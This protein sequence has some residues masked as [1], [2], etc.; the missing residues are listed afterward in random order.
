MGDRRIIEHVD[1]IFDERLRRARSMQLLTQVEL[2]QNIQDIVL[3]NPNHVKEFLFNCGLS[4]LRQNQLLQQL[5][6][7]SSFPEDIINSLW[8]RGVV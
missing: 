6:M 3:D 4:T 2:T 7:Q 1:Q 8:Q 5:S